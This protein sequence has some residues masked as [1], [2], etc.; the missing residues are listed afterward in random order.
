[1]T[2]INMD[3]GRINADGNCLIALSKITVME[4]YRRERRVRERGMK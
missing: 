4:V 1:M 2:V 3:S